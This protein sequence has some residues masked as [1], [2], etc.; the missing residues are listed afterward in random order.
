[1]VLYIPVTTDA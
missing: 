1:E